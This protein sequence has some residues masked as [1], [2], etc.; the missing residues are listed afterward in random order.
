ML[1]FE[2]HVLQQLDPLGVLPL[3]HILFVS[4]LVYLKCHSTAVIE[5]AQKRTGVANINSDGHGSD[6]VVVVVGGGGEGTGKAGGLYI[7][8]NHHLDSG[9]RPTGGHVA[10]VS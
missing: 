4:Q 6:G 10:S 1:P 5:G 2:A 9:I 8:F 7:S 3:V